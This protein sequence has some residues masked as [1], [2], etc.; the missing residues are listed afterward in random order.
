MPTNKQPLVQVKDLVVSFGERRRKF[1]A[2]KGV[3]FRYPS[4]RNLRPG[5]G[6]GLR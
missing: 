6:V 1:Q 5:G 3:I 4:R 2:V